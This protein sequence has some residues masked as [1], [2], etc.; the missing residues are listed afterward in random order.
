MPPAV[1]PAGTEA[2]GAARWLGTATGRRSP[3]TP[4]CHAACPLGSCP[5]RDT[6]G[7]PQCSEH[8]EPQPGPR[9]WPRP[10]VPTACHRAGGVGGG[11]VP[12]GPLDVPPCPALVP[13]VSPWSSLSHCH[14]P[15]TP[16]SP[17]SPIH[18]PRHGDPRGAMRWD[19]TAGGSRAEHGVPNLAVPQGC[20]PPPQLAPERCWGS[21]DT[22]AHGRGGGSGDKA[23]RQ[24][25]L[26][27]PGLGGPAL[28]LVTPRSCRGPGG[29][30]AASPLV[31]AWHLGRPQ[32]PATR[33]EVTAA[34]GTGAQPQRR[35]AGRGRGD[36]GSR[37]APG[38]AAGDTRPSDTAAPGRAGLGR[39][40]G[41]GPLAAGGST[42]VAS[43]PVAPTG[44]VRDCPL[45]MGTHWGQNQR[46]TP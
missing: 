19:V 24:S 14:V 15:I 31:I 4:R 5:R 27:A 41:L 13:P 44:C 2:A 40:G 3:S 25:S 26:C 38:A 8:P 16:K 1:S 34:S 46:P 36:S 21:G 37:A 39:P 12:G 29:W 23:L 10:R 28:P 6:W 33:W 30:G 42:A 35:G 32:R 11:W 18:S 45:S 9:W 43:A 17:P 22:R 7:Q 20:A